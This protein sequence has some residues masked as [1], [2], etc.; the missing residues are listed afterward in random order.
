MSVK[1]I[2]VHKLLREYLQAELFGED[3]WRGM[4]KVFMLD[5]RIL[6]MEDL[7]ANIQIFIYEQT[8]KETYV[9]ESL[10]SD[11][12]ITRFG[13]T[14]VKLSKFMSMNGLWRKLLTQD[15]WTNNLSEVS[16]NDH[17]G[18]IIHKLLS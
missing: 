8:I 7:Q 18:R 11:G 15:L 4:N 9:N 12:W 1:A 10:S 13:L 16:K 2:C 3:V 17:S 6:M 14:N 5:L